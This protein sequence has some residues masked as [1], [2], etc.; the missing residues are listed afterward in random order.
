MNIDYLRWILA[1]C[2]AILVAGIFLWD[3]F[4]RR[5]AFDPRRGGGRSRSPAP[6]GASPSN[7]GEDDWNEDAEIDLPSLR[8]EPFDPLFS[9]GPEFETEIE[10]VVDDE[11][12]A[13]VNEDSATSDAYEP[14]DIVQIKVTACEGEVFPGS[15]LIN[16]LRAVGLEYGS[17]NIFHKQQFSDQPPLFSVVNMVEPGTFP[18]DD[19]DRFESPGVVFFLQV[20]KLKQPQAAFDKMIRAAQLLAAKIRGEVRDAENRLLTAEKTRVIR[21]SLAQVA[22]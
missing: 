13:A 22:G 19:P 4:R 5:S 9:D 16:A 21:E 20:A 1:G 2:G 11:T 3:R 7:E 12:P 18:V 10:A 17:M 6:R 14:L 15:L 8:A